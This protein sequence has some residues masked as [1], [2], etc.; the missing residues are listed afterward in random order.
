M[1]HH[2]LGE[3]A[4]HGSA[5]KGAQGGVEKDLGIVVKP[6]GHNASLSCPEEQKPC[7]GQQEN[8]AEKDSKKFRWK[9]TRG[10]SY[11]D[12]LPLSVN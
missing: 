10:L 5:A 1:P 6:G 3:Q 12:R 4:A 8:T 9:T 11:V 2:I 7:D